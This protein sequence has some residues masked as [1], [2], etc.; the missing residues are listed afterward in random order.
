MECGNEEK[1]LEEKSE[2][3]EFFDRQGGLEMLGVE[4]YA[5]EPQ[6]C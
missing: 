6:G 4:G 1:I 2:A 5:E 3:N